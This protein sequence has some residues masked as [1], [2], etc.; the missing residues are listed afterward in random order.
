MSLDVYL[1]MEGSRTPRNGSGIFIRD[2]GQ[3]RQI[4]RA[5]WNDLHPDLEPIRVEREPDETDE[6]YSANVTHNLNSMAG[7]AGIYEHLW[8][9]DE[10]GITKASEL[11]EPLRAGL[12]LMKADPPRFEKHNPE[13]GW[14][15]YKVFV[16]WVESYLAACEKYPAATVR[17]SR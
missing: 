9:P 12:A 14:G 16:P 7:E 5:E 13:N 3:T 6:V 1:T 10:L 15:S 17:V 2:N 11:V 8:R 4:S